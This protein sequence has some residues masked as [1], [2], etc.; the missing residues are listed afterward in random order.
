MET[1]RH[2]NPPAAPPPTEPKPVVYTDL[3]HSTNPPAAPPPTE[4]KPVLY[5]EVKQSTTNQPA[6]PLPTEEVSTV[7]LLKFSL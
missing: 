3:Q 6:A 4:P 1:Y 7:G 2:S 5:A